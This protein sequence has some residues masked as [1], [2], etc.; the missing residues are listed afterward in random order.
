MFAHRHVYTAVC[1]QIIENILLLTV[2]MAHNDYMISD[3]EKKSYTIFLIPK[4]AVT[5][6]SYCI[7]HGK[8]IS[9]DSAAVKL[10][11]KSSWELK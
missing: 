7:N 5:W 2:I 8:I 1:L 3:S 4:Y 6:I 10:H 11:L 9:S